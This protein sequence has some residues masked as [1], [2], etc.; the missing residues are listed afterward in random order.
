MNGAGCQSMEQWKI[1]QQLS[2]EALAKQG[3]LGSEVRRALLREKREPALAEWAR[4][5]M[6]PPSEDYLG[7]ALKDFMT[8]V[9]SCIS[10]NPTLDPATVARAV[11]FHIPDDLPRGWAS[12]PRTER[13]GFI[14]PEGMRTTYET[15]LA[16]AKTIKQKRWHNSSAATLTFI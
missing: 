4:R 16:I 8:V 11:P 15:T 7:N 14:N 3:A 5:K 10:K 1:P 12:T 13:K 2:G 6:G 9:T